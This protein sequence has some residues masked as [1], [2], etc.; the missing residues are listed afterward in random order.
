MPR[1]V[2]PR[3][4][5][6]PPELTTHDHSD[7]RFRAV[8]WSLWTP[9]ERATLL[10]VI[11]DGQILLI[12][13]QRGLGAGKINGPGGRI[14][15][16]ENPEQCAIREVQEEVCVNPHGVEYSGELS[17]EFVDGF[18]MHVTVFRAAGCSGAPRPTDEAIP[19]WVPVDEI[20]LDRMW[21]DDRTW[22]HLML[23]RRKFQGRYLFDGDVMLGYEVQTLNVEGRTSE[24]EPSADSRN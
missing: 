7:D 19:L 4:L 18:S 11:R 22:I 17:F 23:D 13:K 2:Y 9:R 14:E 15:T 16:G 5:M 3:A 10:F 1:V 24:R 12:E 8:D 21:A 6:S 20:P